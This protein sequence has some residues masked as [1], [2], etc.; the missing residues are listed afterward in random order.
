[1]ICGAA[2]QILVRLMPTYSRILVKN[3]SFHT[4]QYV[5]NETGSNTE[6]TFVTT[7]FKRIIAS[8]QQSVSS[9]K[10]FERSYELLVT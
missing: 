8:W 1:M 9:C 2:V 5:V 10:R 7:L 3:P 4:W 6:Q